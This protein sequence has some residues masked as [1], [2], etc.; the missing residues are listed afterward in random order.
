MPAYIALIQS[1]I[2]NLNNIAEHTLV[3]LG[4]REILRFVST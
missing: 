1:S 2:G 4:R 3:T